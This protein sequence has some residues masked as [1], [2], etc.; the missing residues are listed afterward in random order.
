M[1]NMTARNFVYLPSINMT[2]YSNEAYKTTSTDHV[3]CSVT[4]TPIEN[5]ESDSDEVTEEQEFMTGA[6]P[7]RF[8]PYESDLGNLST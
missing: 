4:D 5:N 2:G 7:Y 6:Q 8:E 3:T 1:A